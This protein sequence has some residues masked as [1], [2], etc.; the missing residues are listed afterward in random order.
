MRSSQSLFV[1]LLCLVLAPV[2]A[3]AD[4]RSA[5]EVLPSSTVAYFEL[6]DPGQLLDLVLTHPLRDKIEALEA[7]QKALKSPQYAQ[8]QLILKFVELQLGMDWQ[9][10]AKTLTKG[11]VYLAFDAETEGVVMLLKASDKDKL[12]K[13]RETFLKLARDDAKRKGKEEPVEEKEY[14]SLTAY[15]LDKGIHA[16]F[17]D[18]YLLTN[19][20]DLAKSI[21]DALIDGNKDSLADNEQFQAAY[22]TKSDTANGWA[23]ANFAA[24]RNA[25]VGKEVFKDKHD[26]PGVELLFGGIISTMEKTP[27]VAF[28]FSIGQSD[29]R[30]SALVP[31]DPDWIPEKR[32][33]FFGSDGDG[34]TGK[35]L[36]PKQTL[37]SIEAFRDIGTFWLAKEDLFEEN[38]VAQMTQVDSQFS[39]IFSGLDF[40]REVLG[41]LKSQIQIVLARQDYKDIQTPMPDIQLPAGAF[42]V[43]LHEAKKLQQ[44]FKVAFQSFMGLTNFGLSQQGQPQF[45]INTESRGDA[46]I[47]S[48]SYLTDDE[49]EKGLINYNFSPSIAYINDWFIISSTRDLAVE[50]AE[51]AANH[52]EAQDNAK[53]TSAALKIEEVEKILADN[54]KHLVAGNILQKGHSKAEAEKEIGTLLSLLKSGRELSFRLLNNKDSLALEFQLSFSN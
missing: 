52:Q 5:A 31:S 33:F 24:L 13:I 28:E 40:G 49:S 25:G 23:Y 7:V 39:T 15:Q 45:D 22:K 2:F 44:R 43:R 4:E 36:T 6:S 26:N 51:L 18:W 10:A 21:A 42:V 32:E 19:K 47:V 30:L 3:K 29:V 35:P 11:G 41:S 46:R 8:S 17:E 53:H 20:G 16:Q 14:R 54:R 1:A 37:L 50:L 38:V 48:A 27:Y 12:T 34:T 9:T